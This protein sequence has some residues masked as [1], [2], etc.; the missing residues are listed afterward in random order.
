M[1]ISEDKRPIKGKNESCELRRTERFVLAMYCVLSPHSCPCHVFVSK[2][3][4]FYLNFPPLRVQEV[5]L[6]TSCFCYKYVFNKQEMCHWRDWQT[7][8]RPAFT[9][10]EVSQLSL[11]RDKHQTGSFR[12]LTSVQSAVFS[13]SCRSHSN[14]EWRGSEGRPVWD[15]C[16]YWYLHK[17]PLTAHYSAG[18]QQNNTQD[19]RKQNISE[20][21]FKI[22]TSLPRCQETAECEQ[23]GDAGD[24][25]V[26]AGHQESRPAAQVQCGAAW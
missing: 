23:H 16:W 2:P 17:P 20:C 8:I 21:S 1:I 14:R 9:L 24:W 11:A 5:S 3:K 12:P 10:A 15:L 22:I 7:H 6:H 19:G 13:R 18:S 25:G 26:A 4:D